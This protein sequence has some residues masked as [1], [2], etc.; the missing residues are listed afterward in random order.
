MFD[1][2]IVFAVLVDVLVAV[3]ALL[4][5]VDVVAVAVGTLPLAVVHVLSSLIRSLKRKEYK[6][7]VGIK[8]RIHMKQ[9]CENLKYLIKL[10]IWKV[11]SDKR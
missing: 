9:S 6:K 3:V 5:A 2:V 8:T 10:D 1:A 7:F 4:V 11:Q